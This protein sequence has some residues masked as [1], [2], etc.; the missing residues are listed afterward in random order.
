[1]KGCAKHPRLSKD[2]LKQ[3]GVLSARALNQGFRGLGVWGLGFRAS[4]WRF[5]GTD[6]S[7]GYGCPSQG[8]NQ[9]DLEL[10]YLQHKLLS[11]AHGLPDKYPWTSKVRLRV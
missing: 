8:Y 2:W 3:H 6:Y 7:W 5:L 4:T 11:R 9:V 10:P 1:M